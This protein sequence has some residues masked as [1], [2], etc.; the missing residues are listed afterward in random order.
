M[1]AEKEHVHSGDHRVSFLTLNCKSFPPGG[2]S[3]N[4][5]H[6]TRRHAVGFG[7]RAA[8]GDIRCAVDRSFAHADYDELA[9]PRNAGRARARLYE[10]FEE[11]LRGRRAAIHNR[12]TSSRENEPSPRRR[13]PLTKQ[14]LARLAY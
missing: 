2:A 9:I 4:E 5:P 6:G 12:F 1:P 11:Y 14:R 13:P 7:E 10:H 8:G 3:S